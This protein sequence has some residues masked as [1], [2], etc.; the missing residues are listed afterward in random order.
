MLSIGRNAG[1]IIEQHRNVVLFRDGELRVRV[2]RRDRWY[3]SSR[4]SALMALAI[5][6]GFSTRTNFAPVRRMALSNA[7]RPPTMMTSCFSPVVSGSCQIFCGSVPAMHAAV[8]AAIAPA[9]PEVIIP[10]SAPVN[11]ANLRPDGV[12]QLDHVHE[13]VPGFGLRRRGL[14]GIAAS[15]LDRSTF[16][17]N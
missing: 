9:A 4:C 6:S 17:G 3:K 13:M 8:A 5:S 12:M 7:L 10:D 16:R 14:R 15:R 11:S 1:G 2:C